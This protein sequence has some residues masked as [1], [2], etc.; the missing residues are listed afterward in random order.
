MSMTPFVDSY[1]NLILDI[2]RIRWNISE[3]TFTLGGINMGNGSPLLMESDQYFRNS[4]YSALQGLALENPL[5]KIDDVGKSYEYQP[6]GV[7]QMA[8]GLGY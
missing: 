6:I 3:P 2:D 8:V 7:Y 5:V 4:R 1:H